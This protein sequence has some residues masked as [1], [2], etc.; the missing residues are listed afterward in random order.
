MAQSFLCL[1]RPYQ[2]SVRKGFWTDMNFMALA[3]SPMFEGN[4]M[5]LMVVV[6]LCYGD[7]FHQQGLGN[8]SGLMA[9]WMEPNTILKENLFQCTRHWIQHH[10]MKTLLIDYYNF[11][12]GN[13]NTTR[14]GDAGLLKVVHHC[15]CWELL[16]LC[17]D[18]MYI[19]LLMY[20]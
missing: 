1:E 18:W 10:T 14:Q 19:F 9:R 15:L 2:K 13:T 11:L 7:A 12:T 5:L 16:S 4:L 3:Q 20:G 17:V 8:C 6:S